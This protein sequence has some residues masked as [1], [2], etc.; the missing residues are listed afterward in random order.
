MKKLARQVHI[1]E[2]KGSSGVQSLECERPREV[3]KMDSFGIVWVPDFNPAR[4]TEL[5]T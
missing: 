1:L 2:M 3:G 4:Y 5:E